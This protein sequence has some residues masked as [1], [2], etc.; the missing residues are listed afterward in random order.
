MET[1]CSIEKDA[2]ARSQGV[3]KGTVSAFNSEWDVL[4]GASA[5]AVLTVRVSL[6]LTARV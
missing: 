4:S 5:L 2:L 3:S 1:K 6:L